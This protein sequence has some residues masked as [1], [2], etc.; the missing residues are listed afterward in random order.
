MPQRRNR[1]PLFKARSR[2]L[3][4]DQNIAETIL[5]ESLRNGKLKGFKFRR[6]YPIS[7]YILDF[8]CATAALVVELDGSS[9]EGREEYDSV[10]DAWLKT[11]GLFVIRC[12]NQE[13]YENLDELV[14]LIWRRCCERSQSDADA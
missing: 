10:R 13:V 9:H 4:A 11:Q 3:R 2:E 7:S 6:Q 5:W 12:P 14:E 8:Y 1:T